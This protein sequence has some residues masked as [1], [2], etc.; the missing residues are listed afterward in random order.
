MNV[1]ARQQSGQGKV[2]FEY[3]LYLNVYASVC[4]HFCFT[5]RRYALNQ[6]RDIS[7]RQTYGSLHAWKTE[8]MIIASTSSIHT[9]RDNH[10]MLKMWRS[11]AILVFLL[12]SA[13]S[14]RSAITLGKIWML[15]SVCVLEKREFHFSK[16]L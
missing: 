5:S 13:D 16:T 3:K 10:H 11:Q 14:K 4:S 7:Y 15:I 6:I 8:A 12:S 9:D 2:Q 1:C